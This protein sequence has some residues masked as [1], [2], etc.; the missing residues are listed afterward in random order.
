MMAM[1]EA[2]GARRLVVLA[3]ALAVAL[4]T[5]GCSGSP[6]PLSSHGMARSPVYNNDCGVEG[7]CFR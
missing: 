3:M 1:M 7:T 2:V 6:G 4:S 5:M